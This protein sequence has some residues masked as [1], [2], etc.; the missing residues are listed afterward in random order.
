[1]TVEAKPP[2]EEADHCLKP[3]DGS[4]ASSPTQPTKKS[5]CIESN[6]SPGQAERD[7]PVVTARE[8]QQSKSKGEAEQPTEKGE[9]SIPMNTSPRRGTY[10]DRM[11]GN[12]PPPEFSDGEELMSD[13][14]EGEDGDDDP[15]CPTIRVKKST[16][17]RIRKI[18]HRAI[19]FRVLGTVFPF[20]FLQRRVMKMWAKTGGIK[21]GDIGNGYYQ[22]IFDSQLDH[23]R[24]LYG[25][26]W[27]VE[28]HY[29]VAEPWRLDFDPD[30]DTI[31]RTSVWVRLPRL[32]LAYFDEEILYS[33]G[34]KLG[35]VEKIDYNTANGF[36]GNYARICVE[37]DLRKKLVSKYR[38]KRRVRRVEY[39]GLHIVCF[40]CGHYGH[41]EEKCP[42]RMEG[43]VLS[44]EEK[45]K[46]QMM[47]SPNLEVRPEITEDFGPWMLATRARRRRQPM[48]KTDNNY[49]KEEQQKNASGSRYTALE[50]EEERNE[51]GEVAE[52]EQ[53]QNDQNETEKVD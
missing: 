27:T 3:P 43:T 19:T 24:A 36:R 50:E 49:K 28:D 1:M 5:K 15:E 2:S 52:E 34:E 22:A 12:T 39:E 11:L 13:E 46:D 31:D 48:K 25:G 29:I 42:I 17:A 14:S 41:K 23:D 20:A 9:Q 10:K 47:P 33:I 44:P 53:E 8:H 26:P 40:E 6:G 4:P 45:S 32:P 37:I 51:E 38:L 7:F 16:N 21:I 30:Y 18:W 35:R